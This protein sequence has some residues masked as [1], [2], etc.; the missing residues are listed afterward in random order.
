MGVCSLPGNRSLPQTYLFL[1]FSASVDID[2]S[3]KP[4]CQFIVHN[5]EV[6]DNQ[7]KTM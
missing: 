4:N 7:I 2:N 6:E 5:N 1:L 3:V